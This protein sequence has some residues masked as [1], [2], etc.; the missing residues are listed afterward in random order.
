MILLPAVA[1]I[2]L[3]VEH[4]NGYLTMTFWSYIARFQSEDGPIRDEQNPE[5]SDDSSSKG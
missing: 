5:S 3:F 4:H 2:E 1:R